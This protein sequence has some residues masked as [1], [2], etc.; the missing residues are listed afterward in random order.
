MSEESI[1]NFWRFRSFFFWCES[2]YSF[3][4]LKYR[5]CGGTLCQVVGRVLAVFAA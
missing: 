2:R 4:G 5:L 3:Y 1:L